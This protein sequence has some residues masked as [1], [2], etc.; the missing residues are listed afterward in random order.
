MGDLRLR[1][2]GDRGM[3]TG[4]CGGIEA[5]GIAR[6]RVSTSRICDR[7]ASVPTL[8]EAR[9]NLSSPYLRRWPLLTQALR[10]ALRENGCP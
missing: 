3:F 10:E 4:L 9:L 1:K 7:R 6:T 5:L 8:C 2:G